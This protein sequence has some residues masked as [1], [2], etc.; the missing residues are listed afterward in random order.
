[1]IG[2][3]PRLFEQRATQP[4]AM[5]RWLAHSAD[6]V[7]ARVVV[8]IV[9]L[10]RCHGCSRCPGFRPACVGAMPA[11]TTRSA[12]DG[13]A[14]LKAH[15]PTRPTRCRQPARAVNWGSRNLRPFFSSDCS[16][17]FRGLSSWRS[18]RSSQR[19]APWSRPCRAARGPLAASESEQAGADHNRIACASPRRRIIAGRYRPTSR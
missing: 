15:A 12:G 18:Q 11:I 2:A 9:S 19:Y 10:T 4:Q 16:M 6:R 7:D 13:V 8:C 5:P 14:I 3:D 1:M 17:S